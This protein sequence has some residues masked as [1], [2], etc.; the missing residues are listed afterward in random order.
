MENQ[1]DASD[2]DIAEYEEDNNILKS[3]TV[4]I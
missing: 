4:P 3:K 2:E 1:E